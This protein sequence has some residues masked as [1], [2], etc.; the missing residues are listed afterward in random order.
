MSI[1]EAHSLF[2]DWS[3]YL[4][5]CVKS[6]GQEVVWLLKYRDSSLA[7]K[8]LSATFLLLLSRPLLTKASD[9]DTRTLCDEHTHSQR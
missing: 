2:E 6:P 9:S 8:K 7:L 4:T 5:V 1:A 3:D